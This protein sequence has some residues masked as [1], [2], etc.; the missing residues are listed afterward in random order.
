MTGKPFKTQNDYDLENLESS[1]LTPEECLEA[2]QEFEATEGLSQGMT[3]Y[4]YYDFIF[5]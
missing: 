3:L 5:S 2:Q 1:F 4:E